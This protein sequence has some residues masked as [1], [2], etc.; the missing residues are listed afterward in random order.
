MTYACPTWEFT[1]NIYLMKLQ[2]FQRKVL[3]TAD[4][5]ARRLPIRDTHNAF[6]NSKVYDY[7]SKL[8]KQQAQIFRN[9]E[10]SYFRNIGQG[11]A[12]GRKYRRIKLGSEQAHGR[13]SN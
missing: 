2:R 7:I 3:R 10:N 1:E 4:K 13:E 9:N 8:Y 11:D 12:L 5:I 6:Q